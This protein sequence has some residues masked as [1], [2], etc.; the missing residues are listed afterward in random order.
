MLVLSKLSRSL[1]ILCCLALVAG[2]RLRG[3]QSESA[4]APKQEFFE[5]KVRPLLAKNCF[6]CHTD[7]K[8][9][10][11]QLNTRE[12][13]LKGGKRGPAVVP[14]EPESSLLIRAVNHTDPKLEMPPPGKL[15]SD[16]IS[17]LELWVKDG[18]IW[19][20]PSNATAGASSE[21]V[22]SPEQRA[23]WS[24]QPVRVPPIPKVTDRSWIRSPIDAFILAKLE[25]QGLKP[26][27]PAAKTTLI[28]RA[29][30]DLIGLP[31]A[32]E[33]VDDFVRDKS[34]NAFEKVVDRLLESPH[35][36]ERWGRYWLDV[37]R[38][39]DAQLTAEGDR[40]EVYWRTWFLCA[41]SQ[42]RVSRRSCGCNRSRFP[43]T[44][45]GLC[46]VS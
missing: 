25:A 19:G 23:F 35:Y 20:K 11:L 32:P 1:G 34:P 41:Q 27:R 43:G 46:A 12:N 13:L 40:R 33:Q 30:L 5:L 6:A 21:Y 15:T 14:G 44:H 45:C 7:A 37:A 9:G 39:S 29:S 36:G 31:P 24:F 17:I 8:M 38:Y 16:E 10:G 2:T 18:A 3:A 28:R 22:I 42:R 26:V 4:L